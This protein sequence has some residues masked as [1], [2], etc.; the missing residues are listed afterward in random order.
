MI[1]P[2]TGLSFFFFACFRCANPAEGGSNRRKHLQKAGRHAGRQIGHIEDGRE[3]MQYD[4][5]MFQNLVQHTLDGN[6]SSL[7]YHN[8]HKRLFMRYRRHNDP[9]SSL[10]LKVA[11]AR[12][13]GVK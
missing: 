2:R 1:L 5:I 10:N 12:K 8:I 7:S 9:P 11:L 13:K 3:R 6:P 4:P